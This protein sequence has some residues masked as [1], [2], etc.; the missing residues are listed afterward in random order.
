MSI[1]RSINPHVT[2]EDNNEIS[3]YDNN[4]EQ[5]QIQEVLLLKKIAF[6]LSHM[7]DFDINNQDIDE[8]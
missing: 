5:L 7:V 4:S 2:S 3:V 6:Y 1:T 8:L